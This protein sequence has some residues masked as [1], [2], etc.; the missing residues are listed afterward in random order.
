MRIS[1][2]FQ[3]VIGILLC[4]MSCEDVRRKSISLMGIGTLYIVTITGAILETL[5]APNLRIVMR[6]A[7]GMIG[8]VLLLIAR[9]SHEKVGYGDG[10]V[11]LAI[12]LYSGLERIFVMLC[13]ALIITMFFSMIM[14]VAKRLSFKSRVPF[15]PFLMLA[16]IP[17]SF[18]QYWR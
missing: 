13:A 15:I 7:G 9:A 11:V 10:L 8:A 6:V 1:I 17:L 3:I 12:G 18:Y 4:I 2:V 14:I 16:Y 5:F